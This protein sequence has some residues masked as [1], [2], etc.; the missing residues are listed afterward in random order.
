MGVLVQ[1]G[2]Y[3]FPS[4]SFVLSFTS[5]SVKKWNV[6]DSTLVFLFWFC[7]ALEVVGRLES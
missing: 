2:F 1:T 6:E 5:L 4:S 3:S 7:E